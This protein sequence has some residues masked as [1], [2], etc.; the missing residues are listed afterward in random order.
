MRKDYNKLVRD[1]QVELIRKDGNTC[2]YSVLRDP[3]VVDALVDKMVEEA[4]EIRDAFMTR[5]RASVVEELGDLLE[6]IACYMQRD[7]ISDEEV[8]KAR[9]EKGAQ[10]GFFN[11]GVKLMHVDYAE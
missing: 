7:G 5:D 6:V 8:T 11:I 9:I 1:R 10:K 3:E 4:L 2:S